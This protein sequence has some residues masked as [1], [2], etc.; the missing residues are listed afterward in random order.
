MVKAL[1]DCMI[2]S[3]NPQHRAVLTLTKFLDNPDVQKLL[4]L[5]QSR[6]LGLTPKVSL[7]FSIIHT[8]V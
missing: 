5:L 4:P 3:K 1:E 2:A 7:R 6:L 8:Y